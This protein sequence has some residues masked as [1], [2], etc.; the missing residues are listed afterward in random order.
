M[1]AILEEEEPKKHEET[2]PTEEPQI[3]RDTLGG[4]DQDT[5]TN[6]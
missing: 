4:D 5:D 1:E 6:S 3:D 2:K